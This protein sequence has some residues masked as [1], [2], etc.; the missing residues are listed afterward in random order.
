MN[1]LKR[2]LFEQHG[3]A[4]IFRFY[5]EKSGKTV[6]YKVYDDKRRY[7]VTTDDIEYARKALTI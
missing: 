7:L 1:Q 5:N 3:K 2:E 4:R 6:S